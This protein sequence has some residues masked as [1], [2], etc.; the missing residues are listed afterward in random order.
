MSI[1]FKFVLLITFCLASGLSNAQNRLSGGDGPGASRGQERSGPGKSKSDAKKDTVVFKMKVFQLQNGYTQVHETKLDTV[2]ADYQ[3]YNPVLKKSVTAQTLGIMGGSAQN[4]DF[5]GRSFDPN[6]FLFLRN[7]QDYGT[8]PRDVRFYNTTKPFTLLEYGQWFSNKPNGESWL[9]VFQTQNINP[10]LNFGFSYSSISSNGKYLNQTA[11]DNSLN[12]FASY[13]I[14][15]YDLWFIIGKN[16]FTNQENGGL[17]YPADIENPDLKPENLPVWLSGANAETKNSF[18][19][20]AHQ[21]KFGKWIKVKEKDEEFQKFITRFAL[22]H[23]LEFSD[24]SRYFHEVE[25]NP[26]Y[27]LSDS[28]GNVY[29]YGT[30]HLPYIKS[31]TGTTTLP[32]TQDKT[33]MKRVT[34]LFYLK[35]VETPDRKYTFGKQAYIGNDLINFYFPRERMIYTPGI[36]M[37]P[38]GLTQSKNLTN[39]FVGGSIFS[40]T[41]KFWNWNGTGRYYVQGYRFADFDLQGRIEKPIRTSRDTSYIRISGGMTNTTPDYLYNH[42]YSNHYKWENSFDKTYELKLGVAY[43]KPFRRFK[44]GFKYSIINNF[45]Y[46]DEAALPAQAKSEFSV[47]QIFLNKD[48]KFGPLNLQNSFLFQKSTTDKYL[49]VPQLSTK[50]AMFLNGIISKVLTFQMGF[51]LRYDS[52]YYADYYSPALGTFYV[53]QNEKIGNYPWID[54]FINLKIKRTRFYVKYNN[55]GNKFVRS[56]YYTTPGYAA[57]IASACFGL[58]WTFYD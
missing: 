18:G 15:R 55:L 35:A 26:F 43:E 50:N 4:N 56:G 53:Q 9:R 40:T 16:K 34:N 7:Y 49:H 10:S 23:T 8:W 1:Q 29:F 27:D 28:R 5:F 46:W 45:I 6:E 51:E 17:L 48:F 44:A 54:A 37:P 24:N 12:L 13:N 32:S 57:Q 25:P 52:K 20:I 11:K 19:V 30:E 38:L 42:Y 3:T 22:M 21:Y 39:T 36:L 2:F 58:S 14:D 33:G 41:S 47:A 31:T